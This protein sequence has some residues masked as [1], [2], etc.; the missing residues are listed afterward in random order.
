MK[1]KEGGGREKRSIR[2][3]VGGKE[4]GATRSSALSGPGT[5]SDTHKHSPFPEGESL[6]SGGTTETADKGWFGRDPKSSQKKRT[7]KKKKGTAHEEEHFPG[8]K[9]KKKRGKKVGGRCESS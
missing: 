4:R 3:K 9:P 5:S 8:G 1:K 6:R 7:Y 2:P